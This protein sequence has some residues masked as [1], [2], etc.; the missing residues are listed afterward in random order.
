MAQNVPWF[1]LLELTL[2]H[3]EPDFEMIPD[4]DIATCYTVVLLFEYPL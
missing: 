3:I 1:Q 2:T 4:P